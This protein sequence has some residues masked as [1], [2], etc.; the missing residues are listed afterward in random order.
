[1]DID[2][3]TRATLQAFADLVAASPHNLVSKRARSELM[4]RHI[5]E[6]VAFGA[7]LPEGPHRVLDV[8]SGGGFP[9]L[10]I[11]IVRPELEIHLLDSTAKKT[12]F[13]AE[14]AE[15]LDVRVDVHTGRVEQLMTGDLAGTFDLVTARALAPLDRLV[16][17]T[18]P[19]LRVGGALCAIKG[20][21]WATEL[22]D[23]EAE[24]QRVGAR[25]RS[26]PPADVGGSSEG[27]APRVVMIE[28]FR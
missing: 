3:R 13:L 6:C 14:A 18:V 20:E 1:M 25:V 22:A 12:A 24:L 23:A 28:R 7:Q 16:G 10:V 21:R 4:T 26:T 2:T 5:P 19:F 8:G 17:W 27:A 11:A 9:G 15:A